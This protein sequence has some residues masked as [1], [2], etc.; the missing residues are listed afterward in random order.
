MRNFAHCFRIMKNFI[1]ILGFLILFSSCSEFQ[2][3]LKSEDIKTKFDLGSKL[4]EEGKWNKAN[5]L[6]AQI[7]PKYRG[8]PQ[9]E[10]LMYMFYNT[11]YMMKDYHI[12]AYHF[13]R[14]CNVLS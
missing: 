2:K 8:K 14:F 6:F 9:A 10:K 3:A 5:R 12:S 4:Y 7:V 11:S 1:G 13:D